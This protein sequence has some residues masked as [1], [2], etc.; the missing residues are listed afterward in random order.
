[1]DR[2]SSPLRKPGGVAA[3]RRR[4]NRFT[5]TIAGSASR[6]EERALL[7]VAMAAMDAGHRPTRFHEAGARAA[8]SPQGMPAAIAAPTIMISPRS[9]IAGLF[10]RATALRMSL[11]DAGARAGSIFPSGPIQTV[12]VTM[13][14]SSPTTMPEGGFTNSNGSVSGTIPINGISPL[15]R[16]IALQSGL[17]NTGIALRSGLINTGIALRSGLINTGI[18]LRTNLFDTGTALRSGLFDIGSGLRTNLF[19]TGIAL[20][21]RL[22]D[23]GIAARDRLFG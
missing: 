23:I 18:A 16:G 19:D 12:T 9:E 8:S 20:R 4:R 14:T 6:L 15:N 17:I 1:M 22:I 5:P 21:T 13:P 2:A 10:G 11:L 7:S 3:A